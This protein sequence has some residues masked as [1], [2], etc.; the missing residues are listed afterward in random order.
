MILIVRFLFGHIT[1]STLFKKPFHPPPP[2]PRTFGTV[3]RFTTAAPYQ[4]ISSSWRLTEAWPVLTMLT[5]TSVYVTAMEA[6]TA[7]FSQQKSGKDNVKTW[8]DRNNIE[9]EIDQQKELLQLVK[10]KSLETKSDLTNDEFLELVKT[11]K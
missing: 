7:K 2:I 1:G 10:A 4:A 5:S 6:K 3:S 11:L 8:L 9:M